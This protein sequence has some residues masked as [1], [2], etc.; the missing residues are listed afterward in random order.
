MPSNLC[1]PLPPPLPC[2][3][4]LGHSGAGGPG[5]AGP[6][7]A[8]G[9]G[10]LRPGRRLRAARWAGAPKGA[11]LQAEAVEAALGA[12][13][14]KCTLPHRARMRLPAPPACLCW[15]P[16]PDEASACLPPALPLCPADSNYAAYFA[17][18]SA[19]AW[20]VVISNAGAQLPP[21]AV[22]CCGGEGGER[23]AP[24]WPAG[25]A[26]QAAACPPSHHAPRL[27]SVH[28]RL[29]QSIS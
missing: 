5:P 26:G 28:A 9:G 3:L 8:A 16:L 10:R 23:G 20:E 17:A 21:C 4:P 15:A 1:L 22:G 25:V 27:P 6:L 7:P 29:S 2:R 19:P 13:M 14:Q 24:A 12:R 11:Q 18:A